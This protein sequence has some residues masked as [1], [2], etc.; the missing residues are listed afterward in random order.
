[1]RAFSRSLAT[2]ERLDD[3]RIGRLSGGDVADRDADAAGS[4]GFGAGYGGEARFGLDEKI[5]GLARVIG[6]PGGVTADVA[7]DETRM[8]P[9][10]FRTA[11]T[12]TLVAPGA[13][14]CTKTSAVA[15]I[16]STRD[17]SSA[18]FRSTMQDSL[19]RLFQT[20]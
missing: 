6:R 16:A 1:M 19:P 5:V 17:R 18:S 14:F 10:Q 7:D 11:E 3:C 20:K 8:P 13:R 4:R 9:A 12:E 2:E 15:I